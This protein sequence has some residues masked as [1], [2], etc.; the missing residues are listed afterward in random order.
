MMHIEEYML[1]RFVLSPQHMDAKTTLAV[2]S[3]IDQCTACRETVQFLK[4]FYTDLKSLD[5]TASPRTERFLQSLF[6]ST[7]VIHLKPFRPQPEAASSDARYITVLAAMT[8]QA[9][10]HRFQT[11]AT[12]ASEQDG[13]LVKILHD[14]VANSFKLYILANDDRRRKHALVSIPALSIELVTNEH[15]QSSFSLPEAMGETDWNSVT[16]FLHLPVAEYTVSGAEIVGATSERPIVLGHADGTKYTLVL[17]HAK[18]KIRLDA[19]ST[20]SEAPPNRALL[21]E[22][23][24]NTSLLTLRNG[25]GE[26]LYETLPD[27]LTIRLFSQ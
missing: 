22:S 24:G 11:R 27:S 12:L 10:Q 26:H 1:E 13:T 17:S 18:G 9:V 14:N 25:I 19:S 7:A 5:Y 15:G 21:M 16:A 23:Q 4:S 8:E 3:H 2:Q 20:R 6:P